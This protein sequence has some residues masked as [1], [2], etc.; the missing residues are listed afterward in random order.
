MTFAPHFPD[1]LEKLENKYN[2]RNGFLLTSYEELLY[3]QERP[4]SLTHHYFVHKF[5]GMQATMD[6]IVYILFRI[7]SAINT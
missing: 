7:F 2:A 5:V 4:L 6:W 1:G 3:I